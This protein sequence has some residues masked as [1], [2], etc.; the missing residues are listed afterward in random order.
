MHRKGV[1]LRR[2]RRSTEE[3]RKDTH[4]RCH[5]GSVRAGARIG[6]DY[7]LVHVL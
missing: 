2:L 7:R 5:Q 3:A 6:I 4:N 1:L